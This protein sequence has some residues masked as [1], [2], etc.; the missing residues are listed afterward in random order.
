MTGRPINQREHIMHRKIPSHLL[1][2]P[3]PFD[4]NRTIPSEAQC[5]KWWDEFDMF[6]HIKE[7]SLQVANVATTIAELAVRAG[8]TAPARTFPDRFI[9]TIRASA[10][11]HDLGK[12]YCIRHGGNHSQLGGAWVQELTRNPN[13]SQGVTHHVFWP[14]RL[15]PEEFFIP[16]AVMYSDKRVRH[17]EIVSLDERAQD[18]YQRYGKTEAKQAMIKHSIDQIR[19]VERIFESQLKE[20]LHAYPF[21]RRG[22]V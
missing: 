21:D 9:A 19:D 3:C 15:S 8:V 13:I 12:T 2:T 7:H 17:T 5:R 22:L 4:P 20:N 16:L 10:L 11:L 18:L 1:P 14:G 6:D